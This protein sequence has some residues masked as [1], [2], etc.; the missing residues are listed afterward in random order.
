MFAEIGPNAIQLMMDIY[1]N[2][3]LQK[4]FEHGQQVQKKALAAQMKPKILELST[5]MY[6]CRVVQ[7]VRISRNL[8]SPTRFK[9][10]SRSR[11]LHA[12]PATVLTPCHRPLTT[13]FS[14]SR[15]SSPLLCNRT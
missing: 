7:K 8:S 14:S 6:G 10:A 12:R 11:V 3:V 4:C 13:S 1:G 15:S 5:Q 2:Y 9:A